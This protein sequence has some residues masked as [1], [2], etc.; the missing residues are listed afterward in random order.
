M[1][2]R[3]PGFR[4]QLDGWRDARAAALWLAGGDDAWV[5]VPG[6]NAPLKL[7]SR[8]L[9]VR[10]GARVDMLQREG[11]G[12]RLRGEQL[13]EGGFDAVLTALPAEQTAALLAEPAP[14]IAR[15]AGAAPSDPC[16]TAMASFAHRLALEPDVLRTTGPVS[17]AARNSSKPGRS[18]PESWV[19]QASPDWT[20]AH[21]DH[22]CEPVAAA[23]LDAF[24]KAAQL[25][26]VSPIF[27]AGHRWRYARSGVAGADRYW[28]V[29]LGLGACGDWTRGPRVEN[30][31]L[32]GRDLA[33]SVR[34]TA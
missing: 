17:W 20:R 28:D 9:P 10:W 15:A 7:M 13:D 4:A 24:F 8:A 2:G 23:L 33:A 19:I 16:W 5:G 3:D 14:W 18:G 12:W 29:G 25:Q 32:S 26:A 30:A 27:I 6:M 22:A 11:Q 34:R 1:T 31:W 21:L